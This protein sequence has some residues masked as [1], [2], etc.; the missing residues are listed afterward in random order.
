MAQSGHWELEGAQANTPRN[1]A[2][3]S[4]GAVRNRARNQKTQEAKQESF[5]TYLSAIPPSGSNLWARW[6]C[7]AD[8]SPRWRPGKARLLP[9]DLPLSWLAGPNNRVTLSR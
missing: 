8:A 2:P 7:T 6:R 3:K 5:R 9:P 4:R 1:A